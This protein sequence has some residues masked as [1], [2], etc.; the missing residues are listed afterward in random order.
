MIFYTP[1]KN[2][3]IAIKRLHFW[4]SNDPERTAREELRDKLYAVIIHDAYDYILRE[5][6]YD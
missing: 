4:I 5:N 1:T 2:V 6:R 3:W